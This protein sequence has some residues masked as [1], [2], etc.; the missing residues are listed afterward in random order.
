[1]ENCKYYYIGGVY[2]PVKLAMIYINIAT[3]INGI[4]FFQPTVYKNQPACKKNQPGILACINL[5]LPARS[6]RCQK[7]F[8]EVRLAFSAA[9]LHLNHFTNG[10]SDISNF[11][12]SPF[13]IS[14]CRIQV[15]CN[16]VSLSQIFFT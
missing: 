4:N 11:S 7:R 8:R 10:L 2:I 16:R 13:A 9:V 1:M 15:R 12:T 6:A 3:T 14:P 5:L